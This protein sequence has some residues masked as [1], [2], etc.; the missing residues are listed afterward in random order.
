MS[1]DIHAFFFQNSYLKGHQIEIKLR[2][3]FSVH[4]DDSSR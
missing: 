2:L 1:V 3:K 4:F